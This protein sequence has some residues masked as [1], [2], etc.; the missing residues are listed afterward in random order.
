MSRTERQ[1][2][3]LRHQASAI[4]IRTNDD[5]DPTKTILPILH[6][7]AGQSI[8][9]RVYRNGRVARKGF[10]KHG[11][12]MGEKYILFQEDYDVPQLRIGGLPHA[13]IN[14][15]FRGK[16]YEGWYWDWKTGSDIP[17]GF[18]LEI[19]DELRVFPAN[20]VVP[21]RIVQ[22]FANGVSHCVFTPMRVWAKQHLDQC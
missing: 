17:D 22:R 1:S 13:D 14:N 20:H 8:I 7:H 3:R 10:I 12:S 21:R 5:R 19:G 6:N 11:S 18:H 16:N 2:N 4:T 9:I 15:A